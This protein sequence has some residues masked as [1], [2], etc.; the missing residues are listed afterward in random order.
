[1]EPVFPD[2]VLIPN[3]YMTHPSSENVT[4]SST[5]STRL[6]P[7]DG[8]LASPNDFIVLIWVIIIGIEVALVF[9]ILRK[10]KM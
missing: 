6:L 7:V 1:M 5:N 8:T 4:T 9:M 2:L 3:S 10:R